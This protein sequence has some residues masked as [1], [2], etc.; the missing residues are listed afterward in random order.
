MTWLP[1][2]AVVS[3]LA[4]VWLTL[5]QGFFWRTDIRLP[6]GPAPGDWPS[7][8]IVVP[9]RNEAAVLPGSLPTLLAQRYPDRKSVV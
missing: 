5:F 8:V 4:W 7:V 6:P 3:L 9:A 2:T 1:L